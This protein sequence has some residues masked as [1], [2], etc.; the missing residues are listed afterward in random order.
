MKQIHYQRIIEIIA[1]IFI[2]LFTYTAISKLSGY[3]A[4]KITLYNSP[5]LSSYAAI[6][7]WVLPIVELIISGLLFIPQKRETG[8]YASFALM[9][10]FTIYLGYMILFS[11]HLPC[12]CGGVLQQLTWPQHLWFNIGFT[13]LAAAGIRMHYKFKNNFSVQQ[14]V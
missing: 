14:P 2:L 1:A 6:V 9:L 7:A 3:N 10:V 8:L 12:S 4:F 13:I 11:P 5:L